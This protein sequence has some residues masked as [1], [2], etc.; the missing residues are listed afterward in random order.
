[1]SD[2]LPIP[3]NFPIVWTNPADEALFWVQDRLHFPD[4]MTPLEFS[5]IQILDEGINA[6]A[7]T[8]E[9]PFRTVNQ[10][11][12]SYYYMAT[13]PVDIP[14]EA[15][16]AQAQRSEE[17]IREAMTNLHDL[18]EQTWLPEVKASLAQWE[19]FPLETAAT[20]DLV[21]HLE[22][23]E[24]CLLRNFE[25]H[26]ELF[27]PMML[28]I[29][30]FADL[31]QDVFEEPNPLAAYELLSGLESKTTESGNLLWELSRQ[32]LADSR[33]ADIVRNTEAS[34]VMAALHANEAAQ[35]F[36]ESLNAYLEQHGQRGDKMR[37]KFPYWIEDPTPVIA[38]L[39]S[40]MA[41][42]DRDLDAERVA[43][44]QH[45]EAR[46]AEVR[47]RIKNY[48]QPMI[49]EFEFLLQT[50]QIGYK[51]KEDH[52]YWVD[53]KVYYQVR[54]LFLELG[55]RLV[56]ANV[57]DAVEHVF[58]LYLAELKETLRHL[59]TNP[60]QRALVAE[61]MAIE[62]QFARQTPPA[63][64]GTLPDGPPPDN[65]VVEMFHKME[66]D[67]PVRSDKAGQLIGSAGSPGKVQG[68]AKVIRTLADAGKLAPGDILVAESTAPPW[69]PLFTTVSAIV[70][71]SGGILS[72]SAVIARE[73]RLPAVVGTGFATELIQ[74]GQWLDVDGDTG[75]VQ[76]I[77][78]INNEAA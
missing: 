53:F 23:T 29:S 35:P 46:V 55:R 69:T 39:K 10:H 5:C 57:I 65:P 54:R 20:P 41:Q 8:Y 68:P 28:A 33:V 13:A 78:N 67:E 60:N 40:H 17:K 4:P 2:I 43:L 52:T 32:A 44:Q 14:P 58:Y 61:R 12:N 16:E 63:N 45:R 7:N 25:I 73:Y 59:E 21:A 50:A 6:G 48:P 22:D 56:A 36:L 51:L 9:V 15:A 19:T 34:A 62:A 3:D 24:R 77:N 72:H 30:Q 37:L 66:G 31:Y 75:I 49:D 74:D 1:M 70:T 64:L 11:W 71:D 27:I 38:T 42:P 18:W 47:E 76:I 26:F